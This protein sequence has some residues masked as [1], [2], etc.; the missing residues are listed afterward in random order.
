M[1]VIQLNDRAEECRVLAGMMRDKV[2]I[3]MMLQIAEHYEEMVAQR[4]A[5][6]RQVEQIWDRAR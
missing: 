4:D 1:T 3:A 5:A 2:S 6:E